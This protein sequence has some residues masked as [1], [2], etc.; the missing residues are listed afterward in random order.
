M[1]HP[2]TTIA[3]TDNE[4]KKLRRRVAELE[5]TVAEF[6]GMEE[7]LRESEARYRSLV[8]HSSDAVYLFDPA[9]TQI[10]EANAQFG[11]ML[12]YAEDEVSQLTLFDLVVLDRDT[13]RENIRRVLQDG[14][15][16]M[17]IRQYRRKDC[18]IIDVEITSALIRYGDAHVVMVNMRDVTERRR[19]EQALY[20]Q[21]A[22]LKEQAELLEVAEDAIIVC[23]LSNRITFWNR[24]A[25]ERYGWSRDEVTGK[26]LHG[27]LR[28]Q[29][30]EPFEAIAKELFRRG[31]VERELVQTTRDGS[32]IIVQS[33][34]ALRRDGKG[35]PS[36]VMEINNDI[37]ERK[38]AE[39]G[40]KSAKY[41]LQLRVAERTTELQSAN[42]KLKL[43]LNRRRMIEEML[44]KG[45]ERYKNLFQNSPI[46]IYRTDRQGRILMANPTLLRMLGYTSFEELTGAKRAKS[47]IEPTYLRKK[48]IKQLEKNG[49]VRGFEAAWKR[50]DGST[51]FVRENA[52]AIRAADG[53]LLFYEGTVE[54]ISEQKKAEDAIFSYQKQLR[55]LASE[56]SLA[57]ERERRRIATI[58]HDNI[59]QILAISK[60]KLGALVEAASGGDREA[61][62]REVWDYIEQAIRYTRSLTFEL[63]PPI[64]YELGLE[65]ALEW[66]TEQVHGQ[67]KLSCDF[68]S[69]GRH[70]PLSDELRV[71]LFTAVR[72]LLVNVVKHAQAGRTKVTVR[73]AK[74]SIS[75]HVADDGTGFNASRMRASMEENKG[76]GL[77]SIRER[78]HHLGG[79]MEVKSQR[80]RGTRAILLAPL[81]TTDTGR[82]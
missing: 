49:R 70:K 62:T 5:L 14:E 38:R 24:G 6:K 10:M 21:A 37:T 43:E 82:T 55:F 72:E 41:D 45:A 44:R 11:R 3:P 40:L 56:L 32:T 12:G 60:I 19:T 47:G 39:E 18:S 34:W 36:A 81:Q 63:S 22:A 69:D 68:E 52:R 59:G 28:T 7:A 8:K 78:L 2:Q 64:L 42:E 53:T 26:T 75:I 9:T 15:F 54:D 29:F 71:F 13:I 77:F 57:E 73:K 67:H 80:G 16:V 1:R 51:I 66:L 61:A 74:D 27:L 76:F 79:Q 35:R 33:R 50:R 4:I 17:G 31:R 48:F 65:A 20:E 25:E 30:P 23:D 58:L 46:G